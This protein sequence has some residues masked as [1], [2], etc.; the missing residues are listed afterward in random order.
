MGNPFRVLASGRFVG[1]E[2]DAARD[3]NL[4]RAKGT[5]TDVVGP[6]HSHP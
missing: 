5:R 6:E 4:T 1:D 3:V 2:R